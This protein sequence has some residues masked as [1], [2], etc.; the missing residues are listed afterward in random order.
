MVPLFGYL[1]ILCINTVIHKAMRF[2]WE[3]VDIQLMQNFMELLGGHHVLLN[4]GLP[5]L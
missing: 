1:G 4:N 2:V 3:W 5:Y